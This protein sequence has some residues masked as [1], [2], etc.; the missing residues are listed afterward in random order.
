MSGVA[1]GPDALELSVRLEL[2]SAFVPEC[3]S[4]RGPGSVT[5][6]AREVATGDLVSLKVI[7]QSVDSR[8]SVEAFT[9]ALI[10]VGKLDHPR[11]VR[12]RRLGASP[13]FL[14]Y[15]CPYVDGR[16][17]AEL[18]S[19]EGPLAWDNCLRLVGELAGALEH[20]HG[21]GIAH[22]DLKPE[23]VLI[24][25]DG[26]CHVRDFQAAAWRADTHGDAGVA[27]EAGADRWPENVSADRD[28]LAAL[29]FACVSG[30][31]WASADGL[32]GSPGGGLRDLASLVP[33]APGYATAALERAFSRAPGAGLRASANPRP[34]SGMGRHRRLSPAAACYSSSGMISR[35][36]PFNGVTE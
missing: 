16:S 26:S 15:A 25:V 13:Q 2:G 36:I 20:A 31:S 17:L 28:A 33:Q 3:E 12:V 23:N 24:D 10:A 6:R 5:Y 29:A 21:R 8:A 32:R 14:W 27:S 18:L 1:A 7:P 19:V 35:R 34:R 4:G 9:R 22:G 11:I 30:A